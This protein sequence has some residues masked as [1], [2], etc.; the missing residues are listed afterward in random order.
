MIRSITSSGLE[1]PPVRNA[2]PIGSTWLREH[3][4]PRS[5]WPPD[6]SETGRFGSGADYC[7]DAAP[8]QIVFRAM[9]PLTAGG[10]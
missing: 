10:R 4:F 8:C 3:W 1:M 2:F 7:R 9:A 6:H 5:D